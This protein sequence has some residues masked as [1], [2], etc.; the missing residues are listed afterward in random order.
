MCRGG[1]AQMMSRC[2]AKETRMTSID[3]TAS[4]LA[5]VGRAWGSGTAY[6][7]VVDNDTS[8]IFH[9]PHSGAVVIGRAPDVD[10]RVN[11][12][13]VSRRHAT[14]RID[15]G[16]VRIADLASHN[17]TRVN[18]ESVGE[19]R[20][21]ASGD[22]ATV[23]D[24]VLVLN[25]SAPA[26]PARAALG[27]AGW[28]RRLV[29]ELERAITFKRT[30]AVVAVLGATPV[31]LADSLRLIDVAA[32]GDDGGVLL[33]LPEVDREGAREIVER[34]LA[35]VPGARAGLAV[36]PTDAVDPDTILLEA[37]TAARR[38]RPGTVAEPSDAATT[39]ELGSRSVLVADPAMLRVFALLEKLAASQLPVLINGENGSGKDNAAYAV[40]HWSKRGGPFVPVNCAALGPESLVDSELFGHEK[41]AFTGAATTKAGL[42]ESAG[43]GTVFLDE[44][45]ELPLAVQAK[46]LRTLENKTITRV[47]DTRERPLDIRLVTATNKNLDDEVAAGRF[48]QD[49]LYR[50]SGARVMLPPLRD[51]K[52]EIPVLA[53]AFL[54]AACKQL[55]RASKS[56]APGTMQVLLTHTWPGNIRE[57]RNAL[58]Y[59]A[60]AA[61]D[62]TIEPYD[63]PPHLGGAGEAPAAPVAAPAAREVKGVFRPISEELDELERR[64][65]AEAL[66]AA[67]GVKTRAAQLISMPIRT[68]T[69]KAKQYKL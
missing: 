57:L 5:G 35:A 39:I 26:T 53:R 49:L 59:A 10:L 12:A 50:I 45:A 54:E 58:E 15:N 31:A 43:G 33:L 68:F 46:L 40:H 17:G 69:L 56:I 62:D 30:L 52:I 4:R 36:C 60:V 9:L 38:A 55:G 63:L 44:V 13:S 47:G 23:G 34:A 61:P 65:M 16:V 24:V 20:V 64:R 21:L 67:G 51:R 42:F 27:E 7:L 8:S 3:Q 37:R 29:E 48:R 28:R 25:F 6:L 66:E 19:A 22:V 32:T 11:H 41:G 2:A 1:S 18:G 14:V